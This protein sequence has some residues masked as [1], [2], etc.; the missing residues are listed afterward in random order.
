MK[1]FILI[2]FCLVWITASSQVLKLRTEFSSIRSYNERLNTWGEWTEWSPAEILIVVDVDNLN[3]K[4]YSKSEQEYDII[5][6]G[7]YE[8]SSDHKTLPLDAI[9]EEGIRCRIDVIQYYQGYRHLYIRWSNV[10]IAYQ[11]KSN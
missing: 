9:D 7:E 5:S 10:Q 11:I 1:T 3:M 8:Y 6:I 2:L 4:V